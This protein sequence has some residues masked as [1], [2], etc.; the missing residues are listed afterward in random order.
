MLKTAIN[1]PTIS[2]DLFPDDPM[3]ANNYMFSAQLGVPYIVDLTF[4]LYLLEESGEA[5]VETPEPITSVSVTVPGYTGVTFT[6]T[7]TNPYAY[8]VRTSGVPNVD[9][10]N[11]SYSFV[12]RTNDDT[13]PFPT[14]NN[15]PITAPTPDFLALFKFVPPTYFWKLEENIYQ[16]T[17]SPAGSKTLSQYV[18]WDWV[19]G[20]QNFKNLVNSG[21]I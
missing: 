14:A 7:D 2:G 3:E 6:V 9:L 19:T 21:E 17:A 11:G 18:Y 1:V 5:I 12:L 13:K 15:V 8:K 16:V 20:I 4:S 10:G